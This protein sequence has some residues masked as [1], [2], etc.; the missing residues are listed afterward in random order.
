[1]RK[2]LLMLSFLIS[3]SPAHAQETCIDDKLVNH[4]RV[5]F[6]A[7]ANKYPAVAR[8]M[9]NQIEHFESRL[10]RRVD[11]AHTYHGVGSNQ[12]SEDDI[13]FITR[14]DTLLMTNWK[15]AA[16][17]S[18]ANGSNDAVNATIDEMAQSI[19]SVAP[20]KIFLTIYHEPEDQVE[21]GTSCK[22][23]SDKPKAG[24]PKDYRAMWQN[25]RNRF[26][27]LGVDNVVWTMNY[28]GYERWHCMVNDLWPGN[29]LVDWLTWNSYANKRLDWPA[30]PMRLYNFFT[31]NS[32]AEHDYLSKPW[33]LV[34]F[35]AIG[36]EEHMLKQFDA[37]YDAIDQ[38]VMPRLKMYIVF[39][40][41]DARIGYTKAG[42]PVPE[43]QEH[44]NRFANHPRFT[45]PLTQ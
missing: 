9:R 40:N 13:Y 19:K 10:G 6:G 25:I 12:L 16:R 29:D 4:C 1:M 18:D 24:T 30:S 26:D 31:E 15:P 7:N 38:D 3:F 45:K 37:M 28:M 17:W 5:W 36:G 41:G 35:G 32:N 14:S 2:I 22:S 42:R 11:I 34:E 8:G 21:D 39:D 20:H 43:A 44:F 33:G 23:Y 27:A